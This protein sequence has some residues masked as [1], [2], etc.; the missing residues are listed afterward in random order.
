MVGMLFNLA[1]FSSKTRSVW[2]MPLFIFM[3]LMVTRVSSLF[4]QNMYSL[5]F[6]YYI[7]FFI[8]LVLSVAFMAGSLKALFTC[9]Y[10]LKSQ[11]IF[12]KKLGYGMLNQFFIKLFWV[13]S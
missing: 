6:I 11:V 9:G 5:Y 8:A 2:L 1:S 13:S 4:L 10:N 12:Y 7:C 3:L